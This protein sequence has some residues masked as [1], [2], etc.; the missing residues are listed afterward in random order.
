MHIDPGA[1]EF[2]WD[3]GNAEKNKKH[4][5]GDSESEEVFFDEHKIISR[6]PLHSGS[7]ERS[8]LIGKTKAER[9]L[10]VV[11]TKRGKKIRVISARDVN[12]KEMHLYEKES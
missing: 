2:E 5:V 12:R 6:D 11:F 10:F 7:E 9:L 1:L 8:M 4:D 3:R